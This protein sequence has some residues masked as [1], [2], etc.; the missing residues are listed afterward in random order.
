[1]VG[2]GSDGGVFRYRLYTGDGI[3]TDGFESS[4]D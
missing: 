2:I 1:M 3:F 4:V